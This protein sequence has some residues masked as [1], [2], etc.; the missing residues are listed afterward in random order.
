MQT[1]SVALQQKTRGDDN[2]R[3]EVT[4]APANRTRGF[5][6]L[7]GSRVHSARTA[8]LVAEVESGR[9]RAALDVTDPEPLPADHR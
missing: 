9:L 2:I 8:A 4:A 3:R 6:S 1:D 7:L 5:S